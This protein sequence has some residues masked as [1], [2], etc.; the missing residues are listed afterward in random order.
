MYQKTKG[1]S[2]DRQKLEKVYVV[3]IKEVIQKIRRGG[4]K[5]K[6]LKS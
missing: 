3:E 5:K 2:V 4:C 1:L 6:R